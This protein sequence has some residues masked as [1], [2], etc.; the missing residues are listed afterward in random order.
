MKGI[1]SR[2]TD[3]LKVDM[4]GQS[5]PIDG[6]ISYCICPCF[7]I[8]HVNC[9]LSTCCV[10]TASLLEFC[11][12]LAKPVQARQGQLIWCVYNHGST[13]YTGEKKAGQPAR[14]GGGG[15]GKGQLNSV[16]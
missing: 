2:L 3:V 1:S 8:M 16:S 7:C 12:A 5:T 4:Q 15:G 6:P 10:A 9:T 13:L 14:S 11:L